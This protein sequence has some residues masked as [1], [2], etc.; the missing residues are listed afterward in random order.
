MFDRFLRNFTGIEVPKSERL[1][2]I[3][4]E[5]LRTPEEASRGCVMPVGVPVFRPCPECRGK[6]RDGMFV[7]AYCHQQGGA[8][9]RG[10]TRPDSRDDPAELDL[11]DPAEG[12]RHRQTS[13]FVFTS[14]PRCGQDRAGRSE[15]VVG[16]Q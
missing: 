1:E 4:F 6:G 2:D 15:H 3:K 8:E 7:C 13:T 14:S 16:M 5:I 10:A 11:P 9:R 12:A